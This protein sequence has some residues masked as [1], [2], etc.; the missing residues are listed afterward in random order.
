MRGIIRREAQPYE[1]LLIFSQGVPHVLKQNTSRKR[2]VRITGYFTGSN[3]ISSPWCKSR[4]SI[5]I[6]RKMGEIRITQLN[7]PGKKDIAVY[8]FCCKIIC[9]VSA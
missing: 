1:C 3:L 2:T 4:N 7:L 8:D 6:D 5:A 9:S